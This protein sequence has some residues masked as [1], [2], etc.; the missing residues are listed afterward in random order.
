MGPAGGGLERESEPLLSASDLLG[1][2][3]PEGED[4]GEE[5]P[6]RL[7]ASGGEPTRHTV[8]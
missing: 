4:E 3:A 8:G 1:L 2:E 7:R 6:A 5:A